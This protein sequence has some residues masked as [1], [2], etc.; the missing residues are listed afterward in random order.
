M[1]LL[2][3]MLSAALEDDKKKQKSSK[4]KEMDDLE[5]ESWQKKE[6]RK[7][8]HDSFNFEEDDSEDE[9][10]YYHEDDQGGYMK[11]IASI[12]SILFGKTIKNKD[13]KKVKELEKDPTKRGRHS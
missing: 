11:L 9:D 13:K 4:E 1:G 8:R 10:D 3:G 2:F 7:G 6:V 5:L 12:V